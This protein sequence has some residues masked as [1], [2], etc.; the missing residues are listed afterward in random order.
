MGQRPFPAIG[1]CG[2]AGSGKSTVSECLRGLLPRDMERVT[3]RT[4]ALR[5]KA[6]DDTFYF[7][8]SC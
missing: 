4:P 8:V 3:R 1:L 6:P 7:I 5:G 2:L